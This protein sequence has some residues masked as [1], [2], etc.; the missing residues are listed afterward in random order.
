MRNVNFRGS[1]LK[2]TGFQFADLRRSRFKGVVLTGCSFYGAKI[3]RETFKGAIFDETIMPDGAIRSAPERQRKSVLFGPKNSVVE[4]DSG[5]A[6]YAA[7]S[8]QQTPGQYE[9]G[10]A[11]APEVGFRCPCSGAQSSDLT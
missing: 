6:V 4:V 10:D 3:S 5:H 8:Q 9:Y 2:N 11:I 1:V 7:A